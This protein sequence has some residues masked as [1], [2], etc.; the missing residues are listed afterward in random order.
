M[1]C[2]AQDAH[3]EGD[4]MDSQSEFELAKYFQ[5]LQ[6]YKRWAVSGTPVQKGA[7]VLPCR[8]V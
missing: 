7:N 4:G 5:S 6:D 2:F 8:G 3:P 1:T